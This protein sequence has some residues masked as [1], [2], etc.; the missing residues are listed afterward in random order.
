MGLTGKRAPKGQLR[1]ELI[2]ATLACI[3]EDGLEKCTVR[4]V[5]ERVGVSNGLI[6]FYFKEKAELLR[7]A[8]AYHLDQILEAGDRE[9][10]GLDAHPREILKRYVEANLSPPVVLADTVLLWSSFVPLAIRDRQMAG[11]RD[12]H[13]GQSVERFERLT[14]EALLAAGRT[15]DAD[16]VAHL[17]TRLFALVDGLW[18][19]G[20]LYPER[21]ADGE[22]KAIGL[23]GAEDLIGLKLSY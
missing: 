3:S 11:V 10:F 20:S 9:I 14:R 18:L 13:Y 15:A 23:A 1:E 7:A 16:D 5:A 21:F 19:V 22:L 17:A 12:R 6:R 2:K 4:H 8:F